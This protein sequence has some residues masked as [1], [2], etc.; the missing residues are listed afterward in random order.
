MPLL[1]Q[2]RFIRSYLTTMVRRYF[3]LLWQM[4][5]GIMKMQKRYISSQASTQQ[6]MDTIIFICNQVL[7]V[8]G[9]IIQTS[10][11]SSRGTMPV[12]WLQ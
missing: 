1:K 10:L 4:F 3:L 8:D 7:L 5:H 6:L 11:R 12:V 2:K 9:L